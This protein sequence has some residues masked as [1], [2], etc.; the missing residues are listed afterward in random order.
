MRPRKFYPRGPRYDQAT[1][2]SGEIW[3]D[4]YGASPSASDNTAA[5]NAALAA[6][7]AGNKILRIPAGNFTCLSPLN[8]IDTVTI[9]GCN[10]LT[11]RLSFLQSNG[12]VAG[13]FTP[14]IAHLGLSAPGSIALSLGT[15]NLGSNQTVVEDVIFTSSAIAIACNNL[16]DGR[17]I[18]NDFVDF[19]NT[20]IWIDEPLNA[21]GGGS[22][23]RGAVGGFTATTLSPSN[24]NLTW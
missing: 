6:A 2:V 1:V 12:I 11:S 13:S 15:P 16:S 9:A 17:I 20:A 21:D 8:L 23:T 3:A 18:N 14:R 4:S 7:S 24:T 22:T 5:F 19:S 10:K